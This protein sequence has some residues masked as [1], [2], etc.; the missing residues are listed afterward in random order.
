[1]LAGYLALT[2]Q[3]LQNP[4]A[5]ADL[6][7]PAVLTVYL[8]QARGQLAGDGQCIKRLGS[9]PL[10]VGSQGPYPFT[11]IT[12]AP[13]AGVQGVLNVRQQWYAI[14][15]GQ[16]WFPGRPWPWFSLYNLNS[17]APSTGAPEV[18]A[19]YAEGEAGTLYVGPVPDFGYTANADCVCFPVDLVDDTTPEAIPAPWTI[20]VPYYAAYLA[21]LSAQTGARVQDAERMFKLYQT[22]VGRARQFSTPE[23]LP[24][25]FPQQPNVTRDNQLGISGG[26]A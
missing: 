5:P 3:L 18:W 12:L 24:G 14:G 4:A 13:S 2:Q 25:H 17:A 10:V 9:Y 16:I 19:Q 6:Y 21:L 20:A 26:T 22:F 7:D 15:T 8:N 23:I 11:G 1:M